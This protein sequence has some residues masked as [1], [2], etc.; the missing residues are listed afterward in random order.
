MCGYLPAS[1]SFKI[2]G[3]TNQPFIGPNPRRHS[4]IVN[5]PSGNRVTFSQ[6]TDAALG[7]GLTLQNQNAPFIMR[8]DD[9]GDWICRSINAIGDAAGINVGYVEVTDLKEPIPEMPGDNYQKQEVRYGY[10]PRHGEPVA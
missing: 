3:A 5:V 6:R 10:A 7:Q 8:V 4:L 1:E 2:V 9:F